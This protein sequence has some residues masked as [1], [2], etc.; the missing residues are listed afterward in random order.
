MALGTFATNGRSV[1]RVL[2]TFCKDC[3][4][5]S[6]KHVKGPGNVLELIN[7]L[8]VVGTS[9]TMEPGHNL[10]RYQG[11]GQLQGEQNWSTQH[12]TQRCIGSQRTHIT[13]MMSTL[14]D[15]FAVMIKCME[16]FKFDNIVPDTFKPLPK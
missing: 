1:G 14:S 2:S 15:N 13:V 12:D 4:D 11:V 3:G 6:A 8:D 9:I 16:E 7:E 10:I 5:V